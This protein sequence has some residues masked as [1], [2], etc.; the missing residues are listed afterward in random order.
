MKNLKNVTVQAEENANNHG[1]NVY[2]SF[3]GQREYVMTHRRN[4]FIYSL[5]RDGVDL[6][7]LKRSRP[8]KVLQKHGFERYG[9]TASKMEKTL[10]HLINVLDDYLYDFEDEESTR[11]A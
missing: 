2:I 10:T 7:D 3:S 4:Y 5:L 9:I 1:F 8:F 11:Y 6:K